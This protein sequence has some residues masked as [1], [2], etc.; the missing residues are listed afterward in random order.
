[1]K[2]IKINDITIR[3]LFQS[4][5]AKYIDTKVLDEI[6]GYINNIKFD[7]I[8][9][10]GGSAFEKML[11]NYFYMSPFEIA[12]YI[13]EK[14]PLVSLQAL[15]GAKNLVGMEIY[16]KNIIEKFIK[17]CKKYGI[18][19]LKIYD[20]LND[21]KNFEIIVSSAVK[22]DINC[23]G[24]IIY[25]GLKDFDFYIKFSNELSK[26][27]CSSICIKDV[28]STLVPLK[29]EQLFKRLTKE[30]TLPVHLSV[31]NIRGLQVANY[32]SACTSGC[33]GVDF[34]FMP[35][36]YN[37]ANLSI[38]PF[39]LSLKDTQMSYE[40]DYLKALELYEWIK[41][42]IYQFFKNDLLYSSFLYNNKNSNLLPRWLLSNIQHQLIE[43]GEIGKLD[44][45]FEEIFKIKNEIGNPSLATPIGQ[46]IGSQ[47]LLNTIISDY[48]WEITNDEIKKLIL[49]NYGELP[50]EVDKILFDKISRE[51][52][53]NPLNNAYETE[54]IFEQCKN[55]LKKISEKEEDI[56][57]YCFYPEKTMKLLKH[58]SHK[59]QNV[60]TDIKIPDSISKKSNIKLED[61]DIRK[62]REITDLVESSNI[63]EI[64]LE[65]DGVKISINKKIGHDSNEHN[66]KEDLRT[67][68][69]EEEKIKKDKD[70]I[71]IKSPIVGI[72]Y[73]SPSP[74]DQPFV[75]I[76]DHIKKGDT[77]C[78]IEAMKLMN[79]INSDYNG[80][81]NE[82]F[83][84]NEE[85]V[86]Y[87]QTIMLLKID[88]S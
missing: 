12:Y 57:C 58:K 28:E 71:E 82:I 74:E 70:L 33:S 20:A 37:D 10:F 16:S 26:L 78:I 87:G 5:D 66:K 65:I 31:Y 3:D 27:G 21:I 80:E 35:S 54:N 59:A 22:N 85:V 49:G 77:V 24:T 56:L 9:I 61:I 4:I 29:T 15:I 34:S 84:Q 42:N 36:A 69:S 41:K 51:S 1:M 52:D 45:V 81:I 2:K 67:E 23:Q 76:G 32:Y 72:F 50:R 40:L 8:E 53:K 46:I 44:A 83:V 48:R 86:E 43:I 25:D 64:K 68:K 38:F 88:K 63:D 30:I 55:E 60:I 47:A 18:D 6:L 17:Q 11:E 79:K 7:S 14:N 19:N 13:K 62:L 39:L 73:R 75:N